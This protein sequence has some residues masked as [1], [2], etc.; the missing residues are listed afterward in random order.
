MPAPV[1]ARRPTLTWPCSAAPCPPRATPGTGRA[2]AQMAQCRTTA[3]RWTATTGCW[4]AT[5]PWRQGGCQGR[6][7][8]GHMGWRMIVQHVCSL[9]GWLW[10][11]S[12]QYYLAY[13]T[14]VLRLDTLWKN[15]RQTSKKKR[16]Q[17]ACEWAKMFEWIRAG[18][19]Y[20]HYQTFLIDWKWPQY[21]KQSAH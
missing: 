6:G 17:T 9:S 4:T 11:T 20:I 14:T 21:F 8:E 10:H 12:S 1:P 18:T 16:E 19:E 3:P 2:R 13:L 5:F 15:W 7:L